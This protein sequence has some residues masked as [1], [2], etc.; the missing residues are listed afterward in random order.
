MRNVPTLLKNKYLITSF[1]FIIYFLFLDDL[2]IFT[3]INQK[4]KL[5]KLE[6]QRAILAENLKET[7]YTLKKLKNLNYLES[8]ARSQ[9]FFKK[10][11]EE[12]FVIT[13]EEKK[14]K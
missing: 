5:T 11:N 12:I 10:D 14:R 7:K 13:Y 9:K 1:V 6:V 2:D 8:Y 4:R 3:I